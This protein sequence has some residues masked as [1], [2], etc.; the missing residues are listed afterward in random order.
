MHGGNEQLKTWFITKNK[1]ASLPTGSY[2]LFKIEC[3]LTN[4]P[5]SI[6]DHYP[7]EGHIINDIGGNKLKIINVK[8]Y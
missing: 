5:I 7:K 1:K 4:E 3:E 2:L 6:I 8:W